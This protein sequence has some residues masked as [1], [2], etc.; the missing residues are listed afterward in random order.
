MLTGK[1]SHNGKQ[2]PTRSPVQEVEVDRSRNGTKACAEKGMRERKADTKT[3]KNV[4]VNR[5]RSAWNN[6]LQLR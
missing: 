1:L 5:M 2:D 4:G 3:A 6:F